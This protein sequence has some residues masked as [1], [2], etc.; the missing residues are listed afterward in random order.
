L[1]GSNRP[2]AFSKSPIG[3]Q[4][5]AAAY[6]ALIR[7]RRR[8]QMFMSVLSPI[9]SD[10][11]AG[12]WDVAYR[13]IHHAAV[14]CPKGFTALTDERGGLRVLYISDQERAKARRICASLKVRDRRQC[15]CQD[16]DKVG[17]CG[18]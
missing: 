2:G 7:R 18:N 4:G 11:A 15:A 13:H 17:A 9:A 16:G 1:T 12:S 10:G 14:P 3:V 5:R 8:I 6:F